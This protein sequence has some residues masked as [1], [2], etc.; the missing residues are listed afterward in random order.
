[1]GDFRELIDLAS[2]K[3]GGAVLAAS[4]EFFAG[5]ENLLRPA[6]PV[7][8]PDEYTERGKQMDGWET[9]RRRGPGHDWALV[10][11]GLSGVIR[12]LVVDT[13]FFRG[14]H[15][16]HCSIEACA[17]RPDAP[18]ETLLGPGTTWVEVLPR[19][20]LQGDTA[21]LFS[22]DDPRRFTHLRLN[23][24]PDGGVARLRVH[25]E[26]L[27]DWGRPGQ[28]GAEM[29]LAAIEN[30]GLAM[31]VSD[32]SFGARNNLLL[33]GRAAHA[34][35][36]WETR[37]RRGPGHDWSILRLASEGTIRRLE[38]STECFHG[39]YP[40]RCT[41]EGLLAPLDT[42]SEDLAQDTA[43]REVLP[44]TRL[45]AHTRHHFDEELIE[46]GPFTHLRLRIFP[47]GGISRL[48]VTGSLTPN[49]AAL[50]RL[51]WLN[52]L[53]EAEARAVLL[54]CCGSTA[55]AQAMAERRPFASPGALFEEAATLW[56][57]AT[58]A[59]IREAF[60]S[61]PRI[62]ERSA[63]RAVSTTEQR[64]SSQEQAGLAATE[65]S[66]RARLAEGN[67]AYEAR[68]GHVFLICAT[69]KSA[70]EM[71][72]TLYVRLS[73]DPAAELLVAAAEQGKITRIRLEKLLQS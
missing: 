46:R 40:E 4:D 27:P 16:E 34:G 50:A 52:T 59:D 1:M 12:G 39:N 60:Q 21:N 53:I 18:V 20:P 65:E 9:R 13:S 38:I 31:L 56:A 5:K 69:G 25:G 62:G 61:H 8:S 47:D 36:G 14:D 58:E 72:G 35:E 6:R 67:R 43:W 26:V 30:G 23:I 41:V 19:S 63:A 17:A 70:A 49:G 3:L 22:I 33:P 29:D 10:R 15:P 73:N 48:R 54:R 45:Q 42:L 37:R 11:L 64:W 44:M 24:F 32:M 2:G 7:F 28:A 51:S 57:Q 66:I 68:F 55:W 71:L